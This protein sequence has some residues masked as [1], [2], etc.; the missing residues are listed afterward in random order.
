MGTLTACPGMC[1]NVIGTK[2]SCQGSKL[3]RRLISLSSTRRYF[4]GPALAFAWPDSICGE[5]KS[6]RS[7]DHDSSCV[8]FVIISNFAAS[9]SG[10]QGTSSDFVGAF[11]LTS[12]TLVTA[13]DGPFRL[14]A[15]PWGSGLGVPPRL[16]IGV[17]EAEPCFRLDWHRA[18]D[19][20][21]LRCPTL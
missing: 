1:S 8:V 15:G 6:G 9:T 16:S 10:Q 3:T 17:D 12:G 21:S 2:G 14:E 4:R 18:S 19:L 13:F 5:G 7:S 20:A 11:S